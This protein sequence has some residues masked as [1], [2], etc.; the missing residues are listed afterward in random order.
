[1]N[2]MEMLRSQLAEARSQAADWKAK[3][4]RLATG[5]SIIDTPSFEHVPDT[6]AL[7]MTACEELVKYGRHLDTCSGH[8]K[9]DC[10]FFEVYTLAKETMHGEDSG[11]A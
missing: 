11:T 10:G 6:L 2:D 5:P 4:D 9:C 8:D 3:H 1:M 7:L